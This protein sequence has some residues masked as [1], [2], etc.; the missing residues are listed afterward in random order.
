MTTPTSPPEV[1]RIHSEAWE[2]ILENDL[3]GIDSL[4]VPHLIY[5]NL[6]PSIQTTF[7]CAGHPDYF[8]EVRRHEKDGAPVLRPDKRELY[9][10]CSLRD[11]DGLAVLMTIHQCW[12]EYLAANETTKDCAHLA[13]L[14]LTQRRCLDTASKE[15][16]PAWILGMRITPFTH[17]AVL[18]TL[19]KALEKTISDPNDKVTLAD[20]C[21]IPGCTSPI[22]DYRVG[23]CEAHYR[24][25]YYPDY[26]HYRDL[27]EEGYPRHQAAVMAGLKDPDE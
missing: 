4:I 7:S 21:G 11:F 27:I 14:T 13:R 3:E 9:I 6:H 24:N 12:F 25:G 17:E 20:M 19:Q 18:A 15:W 22:L 26:R 8:R 1:F 10:M 23:I 2:A 5:L 16:F